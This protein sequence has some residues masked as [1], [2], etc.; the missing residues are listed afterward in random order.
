MYL[1]QITALEKA[2]F[3]RGMGKTSIRQGQNSRHKCEALRIGHHQLRGQKIFQPEIDAEVFSDSLKP[4]D[5]SYADGLDG[6]VTLY[7]H[8]SPTPGCKQVLDY[9]MVL[10]VSY[11]QIQVL[12]QLFENGGSSSQRLTHLICHQRY[13]H[14][15]QSLITNGH[16]HVAVIIKYCKHLIQKAH[17]VM[18]P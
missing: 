9:G 17:L 14:P 11:Q 12:T 18:I 15:T 13:S 10:H 2:V 3:G 16:S 7:I 5:L 4:R 1:R 8:R 6:E